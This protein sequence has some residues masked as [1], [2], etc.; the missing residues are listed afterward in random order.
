MARSDSTPEL[1]APRRAGRLPMLIAPSSTSGVA[2][3]K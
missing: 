3:R 1:A 2:A